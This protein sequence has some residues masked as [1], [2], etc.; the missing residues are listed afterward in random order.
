MSGRIGEETT[1]ELLRSGARDYVAKDRLS[2][3]GPAVRAA[4]A[5]EKGRR[6]RVQ[7]R[8]A[9]NISEVRYRR[10]F[11][12]AQD[13][14]LILDA[15][16]G[17]ILDVNPFMV[18]LLGYTREEYLGRFLWDMGAFKDIAASRAAFEELQKQQYIRYENLP[19]QT[20]DGQMAAVEFVSNVYLPHDRK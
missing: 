15:D 18:T 1:I 3:L 20:K 14:I 10:L 11:E 7:V 17:E 12:S 4:L 13:G 9:V 2:R 5:W 6:A 19:L 16:T 8:E